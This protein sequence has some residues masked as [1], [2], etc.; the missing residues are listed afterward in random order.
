MLDSS[1][2]KR[3]LGTAVA[4]AFLICGLLAVLALLNRKDQHAKL[5]QEIQYDDF[6]WSALAVRKAHEIETIR[7][8]GIFY[9]VTVKVSNHAKRVS[10]RFRPSEVFLLDDRGREHRIAARA[11]H[12]W[13]QTD[14]ALSEGDEDTLAGSYC[15][16]D[17]VFDLPA[18]TRSAV[19]RVSTGGSVGDILDFVF[20]GDKRIAL[21]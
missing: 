10:Y 3:L 17:L 20:W 14:K 2:K 11:Q 5:A 21:E 19:M 13:T 8:D 9:I 1:A 15:V 4:M 6:A 16:R 18:D 7:A 12:V